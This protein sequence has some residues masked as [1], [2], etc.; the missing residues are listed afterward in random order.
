[1]KIVLV[2]VLL[3]SLVA[4]AS[5]VAK[6]KEGGTLEFDY[7]KCIAVVRAVDSYGKP[8][9]GAIVG[10]YIRRDSPHGDTRVHS[11]ADSE[12]QVRFLGLPEGKI[13]FTA[14]VDSRRA[15]LLIDT[16]SQCEGKY[17]IV[18]AK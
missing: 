7:G 11:T 3:A 17:D 10:V 8:V 14:A 4:G 13:P 5:D 15:T 6:P 9:P 16:A 2:A 12:G 1:M 18:L